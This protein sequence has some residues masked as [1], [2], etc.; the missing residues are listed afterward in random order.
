M[1][2]L[3]KKAQSNISNLKGFL[4]VEVIL[5]SSLFLMLLTAFVSAYL[6]GQE[7]TV[8]SGSRASA[9]MFAE[10]GMEA[11]RNIRNEDFF[12]LVEGQHGLVF[13]NNKWS[14]SGTSDTYGIFTRK[15]EIDDLSTDRK[16]ATTTVTWQ[17]NARRP[18]SISLVRI[19]S[20]WLDLRYW[21]YPG[22][23]SKLA[24]TSGG[25]K[26]QVQDNYA[27]IT[28]DTGGKF[29][30]IDVTSSTSPQLLSTLLLTGDLSNL[31]V[32]GDY[33]YVVSDDNAKELQVINVTNKSSPTL[34]GTYNA[35][36]TQDAMGVYVVGTKLYMTRQNGGQDEFAVLD[37]SNPTNPSLLG[38]MNLGAT[39]F[40][41]I[42]SGNY[43]YIASDNNTEELQII[44]I[45]NPA[46]L[47]MAGTLNLSLKEQN[48]SS[49]ITIS[50]NTLYLGQGKDLYIIDVT[51][52]ANPIEKS[53]TSVA[54]YFNDVSI[55]LGKK[56]RYLFVATS[57]IN[58]EFKVYDVSSTTAPYVYGTSLD[59]TGDNPSYGI[60]YSTT[61]NTV[62]VVGH[63]LT[64]SFFI[65]KP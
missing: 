47:T 4:L 65:I 52:V 57:D 6:Y 7:A 36:G 35:P 42:V 24:L 44:N 40:E 46:S 49:A 62:Y 9:I 56:G 32:S 27:Y 39:A 31:Y 54:D 38:S 19:F 1:S 37:I 3:I 43:A 59:L 29:H 60:A 17:Q 23:I 10:S 63:S 25:D 30:I 26:I 11:V 15:V 28:S 48:R 22:I 13:S 61:T 8:E 20:N 5:A 2:Q 50:G 55:N 33:A 16:I 34:A 53:D 18:G 51:S 21:Y 58:K 14:F 41:P 64:D 12:D 45:S